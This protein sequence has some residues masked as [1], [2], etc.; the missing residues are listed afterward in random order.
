MVD[1]GKFRSFLALLPPAKLREMDPSLAWVEA[2]TVVPY[3]MVHLL[4]CIAL[5]S[6]L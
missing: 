6:A 2:A 4:A 5:L 3:G 1:Y